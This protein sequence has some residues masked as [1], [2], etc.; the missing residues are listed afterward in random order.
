MDI[1][2]TIEG[3]H[4]GSAALAPGERVTVMR[5]PLIDNL[6]RQGFAHVVGEP[7]V[8]DGVVFHG[9]PEDIERASAP[10]RRASKRDW[11]EYLDALGEI[12][13]GGIGVRGGGRGRVRLEE[14]EWRMEDLGPLRRRAGG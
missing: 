14:V 11:R 5:T 2:V 4:P 3:A 8:H 7:A 13:L 10:S 6:I 9:D 1:T 12:R